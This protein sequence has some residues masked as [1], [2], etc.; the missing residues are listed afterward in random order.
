MFESGGTPLSDRLIPPPTPRPDRHI[1]GLDP[2]A[3]LAGSGDSEKA[4]V[5]DWLKYASSMQVGRVRLCTKS[6]SC[7]MLVETST[8]SRRAE[9]R[10]QR[11]MV[12]AALTF[13]RW[14]FVL[15][16]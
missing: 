12:V 13:H 9:A 3:N 15:A 6:Q 1:G 8:G 4:L 7:R 11:P 2:S 5:D 10:G 16:Q 14:M